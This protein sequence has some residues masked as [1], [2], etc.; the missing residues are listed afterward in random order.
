MNLAE[1]ASLEDLFTRRVDEHEVQLVRPA[2]TDRPIWAA[3]EGGQYQGTVTSERLDGQTPL[4]RVLAT[5][6][7]HACF[8]DAIRSMRRPSSWARERNQATHW[9]RHLL[10]DG[11]LLVVDVK[12][13]GLE[14]GYAVQIAAV[15]RRGNLV[16]NE[17]VQPN[18]VIDPAA[19]VM[20]GIPPEPIAQSAAFGELLPTLTEV[21][22][23]RTLVSYNAGFDHGVLERELVRH[24]GD[25]AAAKKWIEQLDWQDAM[26]PYAVWRGLWSAKR[27]MYHLVPLGGLHDA[28]ADCRLL[29][30]KLEQMAATSVP[31]DFWSSP[32]GDLPTGDKGTVRVGLDLQQCSGEHAGHGVA[33]EA[34]ADRLL[35]S[36][37]FRQVTPG[38]PSSDLVDH[39]VDD[40]PILHPQPTPG[41]P[42]FQRS[43]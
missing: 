35:R 30:A 19:L 12:T 13:T 7:E 22:H 16:F 18:A 15:D 5:Q 6:E 1:P 17:Y 14:N 10:A 27:G 33:T 42:R 31:A 3:Y 40:P 2:G 39:P 36:L 38:S 25:L 4:W 24:H 21:L 8:D 20:H 37:A 11:S 9:A 28:A 41:S 43:E 26:M 23:G 34:G 29:L 32:A